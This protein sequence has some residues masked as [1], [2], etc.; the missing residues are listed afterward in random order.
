MASSIFPFSLFKRLWRLLA[1]VKAARLY[2]RAVTDKG[3]YLTGLSVG[4]LQVIA[5][6]NGEKSTRNPFPKTHHPSVPDVALSLFTSEKGYDGSMHKLTHQYKNGAHLFRMYNRSTAE[7]KS[8]FECA[9]L[10]AERLRHSVVPIYHLSCVEYQADSAFFYAESQYI[11]NL[12]N[13]SD[14]LESIEDSQQRAQALLAITKQIIQFTKKMHSKRLLWVDL[15]PENLMIDPTT[16]KLIIA[17]TKGFFPS[18]VSK[19]PSYAFTKEYTAPSFLFKDDVEFD[20]CD[21]QPTQHLPRHAYKQQFKFSLLATLNRLVQ[22]CSAKE[23]EVQVVINYIEGSVAANKLLDARKHLKMFKKAVVADHTSIAKKST[24][25][26]LLSCLFRRNSSQIIAAQ[27]EKNAEQQPAP[28]VM[29]SAAKAP[30][31]KCFMP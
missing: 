19:L 26:S 2:L 3:S 6:Y 28:P 29:Q 30:L 18:N 13:A 9:K 17:D 15:K 14:Y 8:M 27:L 10:V 11:P 24:R 20:K 25:R 31:S 23:P 7:A 22:S 16:K 12:K 1:P 5:D 21:L 4:D